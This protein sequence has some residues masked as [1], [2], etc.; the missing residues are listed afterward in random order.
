MPDLPSGTVT[1]LF[2][3]IAGSTAL[4]ERDRQAMA[5][6]VARH[7]A[8]LDAAIQ[9]HGG[10]QYKTIG[11][12]V[13]AAFPTAA[14]A[15]AAGVA[16]QRALQA[17]PWPHPP[18]LLHVRMALHAG[19]AVP[20]DGDYLAGR[21]NRLARLLA[22]GHGGQVLLT[23]VVERLVESNLPNG[24]SLRPLGT[25]R[26]RDLHEPEEVFQVIAPG[27]P[28]LFPPLLSL[29]RH[30]TNLA[31]PPTS[32]IGREAEV[33]TILSMLDEGAR[34]LTLVGPGGTGKT[35]LALEI[36]AEALARYPDGV[37]VVDLSPLTDPALVVPTI[38]ATLG[39]RET[40]GEPLR[41]TVIRHLGERHLLLM[42]DNF[43]QVLESASDIA[44]LLA[45]CPNLS[46]LAT[47]REPLHI[48]AER[49]IA[50]APLPLP[51]PG[52]L[53]PLAELAG[54]A[55]VA[56]FVER[57][58]AAHASF[59]LTAENAA[60]VAGICQRLDGLPL[61][62]ELAAARI[63]VLPPGALLARLEQ[64]LPLLTSGDRDAPLRQ[65]TMRDA[66]AWSYDLLT[67]E[68]QQLFRRLAVFVGGFTLAAAEAI[69]ASNGALNVFDGIVSLVEQSL[70]RQTS[71]LDDQPHYLMLETVREYGLERLAV[72]GEADDARQ[73][74]ADHF[75]SLA[76]SHAVGVWFRENLEHVTRFAPE[77]DNVRVAL[78]WFAEHGE[79][80]A[81]LR[82]SAAVFGPSL[83]L[84]LYRE[85]LQWV[86]RALARSRQDRSA[87]R[88]QAL[89]AAAWLAIFQGD[90]ERAAAFTHEA[91]D[92]A[93]ELG[94]PVLVGV[95]LVGAG[96]LSYRQGAYGRAEALLDE[97]HHQLQ[98]LA[99]SQVHVAAEI[100]AALLVLGDVALAQAQ[101]DRAANHYEAALEH[102]RAG[103][104]VWTPIDALAGL[105]GVRYCTGDVVEAAALY[106]ESLAQA[107]ALG[108]TILVVTALLGL[109]GVAAES[110][111]PEEGGRL[112]GAAEGSAAALR[113]PSFPRD[114]PVRDRAVAALTATLGEQRLAAA[115]E[116]GRALTLEA[117]IVEA[118][119]VA[120]A[121]MTSP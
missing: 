18:G 105:A 73:R 6:A 36:A 115:R 44:T 75:L 58:Q 56:L 19:E 39:V 80:S 76:D 15:V 98:G 29:P 26:L 78:D 114:R 63:K 99:S 88:A 103:D 121:V 96:M 9:A 17:E 20:R 50:V 74:H 2:T 64:R 45:T 108:A 59:A 23:E 25:H 46:I 79:T 62:I 35:R 86:E 89:D 49:E 116:A 113:T 82:L 55:A 51:A 110:G 69:A 21:L 4:W 102:F 22:A 42:L 13:Q 10:V 14:D 38:A 72:A 92:L 1:F 33:T 43:E 111:R 52:R 70:L 97:A 68:E 65:R 60:A 57:A 112:L 90:Y 67:L 104:V 5:A 7:I 100:G 32:L 54:V 34:L 120:E 48:R 119:A 94:D 107:R 53:P 101:F 77:R 40:A 47:S 37:F 3:D 85:G 87:A 81:L 71:G 30:P 109:A 31:I 83:A 61:A 91:L 41:K 95:T 66:I 12:A 117:A 8:L 16:A 11:D 118:Q 93:R 27:L 24:V 106:A 28:D 84:G